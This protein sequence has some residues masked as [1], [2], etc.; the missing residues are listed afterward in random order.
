MKRINEPDMFQLSLLKPAMDALCAFSLFALFVSPLWGWLTDHNHALQS[1]GYLCTV[2][3][4]VIRGSQWLR[5]YLN[6]RAIKRNTLAHKDGRRQM[7]RR[8]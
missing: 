7:R 3:T 1:I 8:L 4:F 5:R 2:A 6:R